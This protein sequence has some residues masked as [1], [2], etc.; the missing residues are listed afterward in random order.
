VLDLPFDRFRLQADTSLSTLNPDNLAAGT[1][2][3]VRLGTPLGLAGHSS[4][5][6]QLF[7][8]YRERVYNGSLGLQTVVYSY[9]GQLEGSLRFNADPADP[10]ERPTAHALLRPGG[11]R[12][13]CGGRAPTRPACLNAISSTPSGEAA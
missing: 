2:S 5:Q 6:G 13:A 3:I 12:L 1:R 10:G 8:S 11:T 7:G 9:G 4:S